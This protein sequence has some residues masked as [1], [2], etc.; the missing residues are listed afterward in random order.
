MRCAAGADYVT[1]DAVFGYAGATALY[2]SP[3]FAAC[4]GCALV[5]QELLLRCL[6]EAVTPGTPPS[7]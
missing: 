4:P 2:H 6:A 5:S 3:S 7:C 1:S